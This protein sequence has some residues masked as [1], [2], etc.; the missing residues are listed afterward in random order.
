[1]IIINGLSRKIPLVD[2][3]G[4]PTQWMQIL[5]EQLRQLPMMAGNGSPEGIYEAQQTRLYMDIN[6][7]SGFRLWIKTVDGVGGDAKLGWESLV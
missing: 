7:S 2:E 3:N 1:M 4:C 6:K 5:G